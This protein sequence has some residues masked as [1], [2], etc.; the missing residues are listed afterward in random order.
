MINGI[1]T[2]GDLYTI[3]EFTKMCEARHLIDYDGEG[4]FA[5]ETVESGEQVSCEEMAKGVGPANPKYTHVRW[6]NR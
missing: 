6:Y 3:A 1:E 4:Y 2:P 5:T